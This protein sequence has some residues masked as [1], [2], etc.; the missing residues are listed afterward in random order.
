MNMMS[1]KSCFDYL[2]PK[3]PGHANRRRRVVQKVSVLVFLQK[4]RELSFYYSLARARQA[5]P[6]CIP[7]VPTGC[8]SGERAQPPAQNPELA[9]PGRVPHHL[10]ASDS[11]NAKGEVWAGCG[12]RSLM[13]FMVCRECRSLQSPSLAPS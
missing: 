13:T 12:L 2:F 10:L 3:T 6:V 4:G 7:Q 11:S 9:N 1:K 5:R 8:L